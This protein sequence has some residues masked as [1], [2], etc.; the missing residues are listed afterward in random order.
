MFVNCCRNISRLHNAPLVE[1]SIIDLYNS[2][3]FVDMVQDDI[4]GRPADS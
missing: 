2:G 4:E 3:I 1:I